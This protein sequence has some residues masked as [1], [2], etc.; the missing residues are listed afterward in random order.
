MR[1]TLR[2]RKAAIIQRYALYVEKP[3]KLHVRCWN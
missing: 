1:V 2:K 3:K